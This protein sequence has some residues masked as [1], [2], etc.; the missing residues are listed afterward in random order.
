MFQVKFRKT[1][2]RRHLIFG[3]IWLALVIFNIVFSESPG[4]ILNLYVILSIV[5]IGQFIYERS[6][7]YIEIDEEF[8]IKN[9]FIKKRKI[10]IKSIN[11][12]QNSFGDF[13]I[14]SDE[15]TIKIL[16]DLIDNEAHSELEEKLNAIKEQ[17]GI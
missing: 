7:P 9:S 12:I 13:V 4:S 15:I 3:L 1:R 10:P 8:V 16:K 14:S 11:S 6:K 17:R 5:F 2:V